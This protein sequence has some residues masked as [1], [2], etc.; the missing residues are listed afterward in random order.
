MGAS[1]AV[2]IVSLLTT[3][4]SAY[5]QHDAQRVAGNQAKEREAKLEK[6]QADEKE[7]LAKEQS[8]ADHALARKRAIATQVNRQGRASTILAGST[9]NQTLG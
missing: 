7:R 5:E 4:Y 9:P 3:A 1:A 8:L 2:A 6:A